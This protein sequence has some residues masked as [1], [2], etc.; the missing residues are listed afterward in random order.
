MCD[1]SL[2]VEVSRL[3]GVGFM[4]YFII[5]SLKMQLWLFKYALIGWLGIFCMAHIMYRKDVFSTSRYRG[6]LLSIPGIKRKISYI[7]RK[8][9]CIVRKG[10]KQIQILDGY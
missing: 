10:E 5:R 8:G 3:V 6:L 9:E 7:V 4:R 1:Y 2:K